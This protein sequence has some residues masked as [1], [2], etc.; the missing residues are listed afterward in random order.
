M[1]GQ[2]RQLFGALH[3]Y[4]DVLVSGRSYPTLM[5]GPGAYIQKSHLPPSV[6]RPRRTIGIT[7]EFIPRVMGLGQCCLVFQSGTAILLYCS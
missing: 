7:G 5:D 2:Q 4:A 6:G 3:S 1:D